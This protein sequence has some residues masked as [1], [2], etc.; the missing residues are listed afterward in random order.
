[1]CDPEIVFFMDNLN[2]YTE[3]SEFRM[4]SLAGNTFVT[5]FKSSELNSATRWILYNGDQKVGAFV[6]P[7]TCRPEGFLAAKNN[8]TLI[9]L[10]AGQTREFTVTTGVEQ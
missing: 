7:A 9:W 2:Q 1:M 6:L 4:T 3:N 5:Q 8:Q 10:D